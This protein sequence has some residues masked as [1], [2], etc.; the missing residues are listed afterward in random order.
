MEYPCKECT[1]VGSPKDC[2]RKDCSAW[3]P[4]FLDEWKKFNAFYERYK[5]EQVKEDG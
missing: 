2:N 3:K 1:I 4:W 5:K